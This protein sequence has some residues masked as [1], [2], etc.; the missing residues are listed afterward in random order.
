MNMR[1]PSKFRTKLCILRMNHKSIIHSSNERFSYQDCYYSI[2]NLLTEKHLDEMYLYYNKHFQ[3]TLLLSVS[4]DPIDQLVRWSNDIRTIER[5]NKRLAGHM[6]LSQYYFATELRP[7]LPTYQPIRW[8]LNR[9]HCDN[10][11]H[12]NH[13]GMH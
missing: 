6:S 3:L 10:F 11:L 9:L 12:H 7:I 1:E 2:A 4:I 8:N 5:T 13:P